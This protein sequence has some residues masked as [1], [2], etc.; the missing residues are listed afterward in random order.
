VLEKPSLLFSSVSRFYLPCFLYAPTKGQYWIARLAMKPFVLRCEQ[1]VYNLIRS[2]ANVWVAWGML[3]LCKTLWLC[4][5][6]TLSNKR[7]HRLTRV[8]KNTIPQY[9]WIMKVWM[10]CKLE[11]PEFRHIWRF[12]DRQSVTVYIHV[13]ICIILFE[14]RRRPISPATNFDFEFKFVYTLFLWTTRLAQPRLV[15]LL[16]S[17]SANQ[18]G[19]ICQGGDRGGHQSMDEKQEVV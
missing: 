16:F 15:S 2:V 6:E 11:R 19:S 17:R 7:N 10:T 4:N 3:I 13:I 9:V 5:L 12:G 8:H 14:L 1:T 18:Q